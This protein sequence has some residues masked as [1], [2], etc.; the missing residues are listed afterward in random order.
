MSFPATHYSPNDIRRAL[1]KLPIA[2]GDVLFIHSNLGFF[3]R[4]AGL[5]NTQAV[6]SAFFNAIWERL[7][8]KGTIVVPTFTY[9]F[10]RR[11]VFDPVS[12]ESDGGVFA[13][14]LRRQPDTMRSL[15][16]CYSV[17]A[18]GLLASA[19][20]TDAPEN[21]FSPDS[22]FGRFHRA[23]GKILNLNF[24]AG[25]T[26]LHYVERQLQV[27]Y[28]FDKTFEGWARID[29]RLRISRSTIYVRYASSDA[30][31]VAFEPFDT[32]ARQSGCFATVALGRGQMGVISAEDS[33]RLV[34]DNLSK[35]PWLLTRAEVLNMVP[36]LLSESAYQSLCYQP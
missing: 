21:S 15:D 28:R 18:T 6:C 31:V 1:E 12:S 10:P 3:G 36:D 33:Y 20:T 34:A 13:E 24:D 35:R 11:K 27:P 25:S 32:V 17:A 14:W 4:P 26:F 29:G 8:S 22:F 23:G 9:S 19:L 5:P 30:T 2:T 7:G 16:P